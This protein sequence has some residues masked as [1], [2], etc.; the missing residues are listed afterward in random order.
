MTSLFVI[1]FDPELYNKGREKDFFPHFLAKQI[2]CEN[3]PC[4]IKMIT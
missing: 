2:I 3:M 4:S 1:K